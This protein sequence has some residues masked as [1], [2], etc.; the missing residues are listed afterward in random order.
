[1]PQVMI[2]LGSSFHFQVSLRGLVVNN[3]QQVRILCS[4]ARAWKLVFVVQFLGGHY[5]DQLMCCP[6]GVLHAACLPPT[7]TAFA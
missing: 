3:M 6:T 2:K 5:T 4:C 7:P 1:M